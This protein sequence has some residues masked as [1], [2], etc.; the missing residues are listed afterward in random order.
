MS[1]RLLVCLCALAAGGVAPPPTPR[2][3]PFGLLTCTVPDGPNTARYCG[4]DPGP[5]GS[6]SPVDHRRSDV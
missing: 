5:T 2:S 4:S 1:R 6:P 3:S